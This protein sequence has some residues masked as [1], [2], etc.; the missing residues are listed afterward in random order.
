MFLGAVGIPIGVAGR[1]TDDGPS[2]KQQ[3]QAG[4]TFLDGKLCT[5]LSREESRHISSGADYEGDGGYRR[6]C[7]ANP[8]EIFLLCTL[9]YTSREP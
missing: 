4:A 5:S 3:R 9:Y 7:A 6:F 8:V 2:S 1:N